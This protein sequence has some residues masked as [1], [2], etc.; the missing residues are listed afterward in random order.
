MKVA[1]FITDEL[2]NNFEV[3]A[4]KHPSSNVETELEVRFGYFTDG[5]FNSKLIDKVLYQN[6][7]SHLDDLVD[8]HPND[9]SRNEI[10]K[11]IDTNNGYRRIQEIPGRTY[12]QRKVKNCH[13][14]N[15]DWGLRFAK[16]YEIEVSENDIT[17]FKSINCRH[18]YRTVY[19]DNR[20]ES[21]FYGFRVE[22]SYVISNNEKHYEL[23]L[24]ALPNFDIDIDK[25]WTST[26]TLYGWSLNATDKHQIISLKERCHISEILNESLVGFK[27]PLISTSIINRPKTFTN[28]NRMNDRA[29]S[30]KIDGLH[31]IL[32]FCN[33][34][35]YACSPSLNIVRLGDYCDQF[36]T[37]IEAEYIESTNQY[38]TFDLLVFQGH[39][40]KS[41]MFKDRYEN[42]QRFVSCLNC[43]N[44]K[45]KT[46]YLP[47]NYENIN[48]I[49]ADDLLPID[50]LIFQSMGHYDGDIYKWK[51]VEKLTID[52]YFQ[53]NND[54]NYCVYIAKSG[55]LN[56]LNVNISGGNISSN[57]L[58]DQ[59]V[60][61][62]WNSIGNYWEPIKV[63]YDKLT[64]NSYNVVMDTMNMIRNPITF[65][66]I[67]NN[68]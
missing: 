2:R 40:I 51:P 16:S 4:S 36:P 15:Q 18:C 33:Y 23:E 45:V 58:N 14:D 53:L 46:W 67:M 37:I 13:F 9:I 43:V 20:L 49:L 12:F 44:F 11:I 6:V 22:V 28:I 42:L 39:N 10:I 29:I 41:C 54:N 17:N 60:E 62:C 26:K 35:A 61:C 32:L 59:I 8:R 7:K 19:I 64:P 66:Q 47:P 48:N 50:G 31:K 30:V 24:E 63:R 38:Y 34:G 27:S 5:D 21:C 1:P 56:K 25:W 52:F 68:F 57:L 65:D 3:F 55:K